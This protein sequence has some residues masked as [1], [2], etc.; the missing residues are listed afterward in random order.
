MDIRPLTPSELE[1]VAPIW[2]SLLEHHGEAEPDRETR[3]ASESWAIRRR[4]YE[5]WLE[6]PGSFALVAEEDGEPVGYAFVHVHGPD[7]TWVTSERTAE[8]ETLA[9]LPEQRGAGIG[10]ALMD[11]VDGELKGLGIDDLGLVVVAGNTAALR[12]YERRGL[13]AY[14]HRMH[15]GR[16]PGDG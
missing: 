16:V 4:Q 13:R 5:L 11:A 8:L 12:F 14:A 3:P 1:L 10:A 15:R 2:A 7:D 6:D 9:V